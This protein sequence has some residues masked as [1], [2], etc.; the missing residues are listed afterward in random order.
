MRWGEGRATEAGGHLFVKFVDDLWI[1]NLVDDMFSIMKLSKRYKDGS[2][3]IY[4]HSQQ[5]VPTILDYRGR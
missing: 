4:I 5:D 2:W 3:N 1:L